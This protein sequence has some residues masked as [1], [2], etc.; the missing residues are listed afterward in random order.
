M[1][2]AA[3][4]V[5]FAAARRAMMTDQGR[6]DRS[7]LEYRAERRAVADRYAAAVAALEQ[8]ALELAPPPS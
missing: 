1:E 5:E 4:V 7:A 6:G 3:L 2:L 8:A